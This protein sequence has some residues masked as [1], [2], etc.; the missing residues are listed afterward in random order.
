[1]LD[2]SMNSSVEI[3]MKGL[4]YTLIEFTFAIYTKIKEILFFTGVSIFC[5][6]LFSIPSQICQSSFSLNL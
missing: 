3:V 4:N 6:L 2:L 1:M 5:N